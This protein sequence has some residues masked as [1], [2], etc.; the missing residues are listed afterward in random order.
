[1]PRQIFSNL[2]HVPE[3]TYSLNVVLSLILHV[4][5]AQGS[6]RRFIARRLLGD[7]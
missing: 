4:A 7:E 5:T 3:T 6:W 1:M 2:M